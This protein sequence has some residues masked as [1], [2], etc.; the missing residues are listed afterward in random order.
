MLRFICWLTLCV[1][2]TIAFCFWFWVSIAVTFTWGIYRGWNFT[3]APEWSMMWW[4]SAAIYAWFH[5][6]WPDPTLDE[7]RD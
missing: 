2:A 6:V 4:L 1:P 7:W 5:R 3:Y